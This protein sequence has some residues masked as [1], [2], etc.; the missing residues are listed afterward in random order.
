[1]I[2]KIHNQPLIEP[3]ASSRKPNS[4][5]AHADNDADVSLQVNYSSF[6][7]KA[8][9]PPKTDAQFIQRVKELLK[10]GQLDSKERIKEAAEYMVLFSI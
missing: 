3:E 6:I 1:M 4:A 8:M 2:E 5:G 10:S 9:Q 7:E